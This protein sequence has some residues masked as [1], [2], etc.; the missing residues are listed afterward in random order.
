MTL[1]CGASGGNIASDNIGPQHL[2]NVKRIAWESRGIEHR[3]VPADQ[4]M[5]GAAPLTT[6]EPVQASTDVAPVG[7][8]LF[9]P[10]AV[11][12]LPVPAVEA[13]KSAVLAAPAQEGQPI[14]RSDSR[15]G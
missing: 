3:T 12:G 10:S 2:M 11:E 15:Q 1:G 4:R 13:A 6:P 7:Q 14:P 5:V 9:T 8:A